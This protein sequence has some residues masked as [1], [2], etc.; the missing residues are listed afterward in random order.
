MCVIIIT[1]HMHCQAHLPSAVILTSNHPIVESKLLNDW[2]FQIKSCFF[3]FNWTLSLAGYFM[4]VSRQFFGPLS[5][6]LG[7]FHVLDMHGFSLVLVPPC[8]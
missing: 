3:Y 1:M 8:G 5:S 2:I 7:M 4:H 6:S